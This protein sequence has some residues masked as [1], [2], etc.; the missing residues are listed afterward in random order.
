MGQPSGEP[1]PPGNAPLIEG[2][3]PSW[4]ALVEYVPED[5]RGEFASG[6][7]ERVTSYES[8]KPWQEF[9]SKGITPDKVNTAVTLYDIIE[10]NPREVYDTLA[11]HL[12]ITPAQ[13]QQGMQQMQEEIDE[14]DPEDPR[15]QELQHKVDTLSQIM[16]AEHQQKTQA[17]A[18]QEADKKIQSEIEAAQKKY[19]DIP[20]EQLLMRMAQMDMTA[21]QAAQ[22]YLKFVE[23]I[24]K[25]RPA[26]WVLGA[27]GQIPQKNIDVT[28]LSGA[29]TRNLVA[30]QIA[31]AAAENKH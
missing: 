6:L 12:N 21:D 31:A 30:Q 26:P 24:Q 14:G 15:I 28:K 17:Q 10:R 4:N 18:A 3:D 27:G 1:T 8:L 5:K 11:Q 22:D 19:G 13:A 2:L 20:E 16:L 29:E 7:K 23:N 9:A 25:R